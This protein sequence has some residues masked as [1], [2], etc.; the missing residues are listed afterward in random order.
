[1][2]MIDLATKRRRGTSIPDRE[3]ITSE[4]EA[5]LTALILLK[6]GM[7]VSRTAIHERVMLPIARVERL[8]VALRAVGMLR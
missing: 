3:T 7:S 2:M 8:A 1:M 4:D 5:V 6:K